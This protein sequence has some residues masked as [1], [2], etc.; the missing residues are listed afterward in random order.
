MDGDGDKLDVG[1]VLP[2]RRQEMGDLHELI[3]YLSWLASMVDVVV[4]DASPPDVFHRVDGACGGR[5]DH[6]R[7]DPALRGL[8]GK[9]TGVTTG[10]RRAANERIIIADDDV[11]YERAGIDAMARLLDDAALVCPQNYFDPMPWHARWDGARSLVNRC[12]GRD[13]PG[14]LGVRRSSFLAAGGYDGDVLFE[15]LELIRTIEAAGGRVEVAL[16]LFVARRPPTA[17]HFWSQRI[18]QAYDDFAMPARM[19]FFLAVLPLL[20]ATRLRR[21]VLVVGAAGCIAMAECGRRR[22]HAVTVYPATTSLF[23]PAWVMERAA[24]SWLAFGSLVLRGGCRYGDSII[25]RAASSRRRL[26]RR[27]RQTSGRAW[28]T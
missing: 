28:E 4:V 24:C 15:N 8:N 11:R 23:A 9:V 2:L 27:L 20:A 17:A 25:R 19:A 22:G 21:V 5:I 10:V 1:Y 14:T 18:R 16:D 13:Y 7:P 6:L 26:R 12:L 3:D